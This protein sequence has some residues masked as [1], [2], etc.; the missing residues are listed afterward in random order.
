M[1]HLAKLFDQETKMTRIFDRSSRAAKRLIDFSVALTLLVFFSP[2]V[3]LAAVVIWVSS[4]WPVWFIQIRPGLHGRPFKIF[5]L[6][7]MSNERDLE[8]ELLPDERRLG[9]IGRVLRS[10]SVDELPQLLNV[11]N[12]S[13]SL[14]GPRPLLTE[15]LPLYSKRQA[16]RH[17]VRPGITGYSQ[18]NGRNES[19]WETRLELDVWYVENWSL[20]LDFK[21]L[22]ATV[23]TV[24]KRKGVNQAGR[25]TVEKFR[26]NVGAD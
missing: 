23:A 12:G 16:K 20:T 3:V 24:L 22:F 7:T 26:G 1:V 11:L 17:E 8:G 13:M 21:I 4:G 9:R 18:V 2:L 25:A 19:D 5:K 15:Y 14:V 10:T 6:R